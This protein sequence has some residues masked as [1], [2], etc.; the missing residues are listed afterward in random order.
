MCCLIVSKAC[1]KTDVLCTKNHHDRTV[2]S[3]DTLYDFLLVADNE[4]GL[5][6]KANATVLFF[7]TDYFR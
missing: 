2:I 4:N 6:E 5:G 1:F 7:F 3:N